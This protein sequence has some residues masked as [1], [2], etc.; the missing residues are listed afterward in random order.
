MK[1]LFNKPEFLKGNEESINASIKQILPL[2]TVIG[3]ARIYSETFIYS[4]SILDVKFWDTVVN[5][6]DKIPCPLGSFV[7]VEEEA[8]KQDKLV[9][10]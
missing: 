2:S 10:Y 7:L 1:F 9:K 3:K 6:T 4:T 5:I 8:N